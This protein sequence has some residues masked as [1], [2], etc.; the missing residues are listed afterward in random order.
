MD[1]LRC[2]ILHVGPVMSASP[3]VDMDGTGPQPALK[4]TAILKPDQ[5]RRRASAM[6]MPAREHMQ[7]VAC[8]GQIL[9]VGP[10]MS[11]NPIVGMAGTGPRPPRK[12]KAA[13][14]PSQH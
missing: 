6:Q 8:D 4:L 10:M 12:L 5:Y 7:G 14:K 1:G 13:L 3:I 9:H 11:A 2:Q